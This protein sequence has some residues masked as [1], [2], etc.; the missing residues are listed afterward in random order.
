MDALGTVFIIEEN[1]YVCEESHR[2]LISGA[3]KFEKQASQQSPEDTL[4]PKL[5][6][7]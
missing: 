4:N 2:R 7:L 5:D 1:I 3:F 6:S